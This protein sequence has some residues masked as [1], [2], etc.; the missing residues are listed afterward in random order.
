MHTFAK[1]TITQHI[2]AATFCTGLHAH[3]FQSMCVFVASGIQHAMRI[4]HI[5]ICGLP[6]STIFFHIFSQRNDFRKKKRSLS[7]K[8]VLI[9]PTT[10]AWNISHSKT[11]WGRCDKKSISLVW[12]KKVYR[13]CDQKMY[14]ALHVKY[15]LFLSDFNE[16]WNFSIDFRGMPKYQISWISVWWEPSCF[17]RT[18]M[19]KLIV[20]FCNFAEAPKRREL[21]RFQT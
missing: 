20:P 13:W 18:D 7:I 21:G 12:S 16:T 17:K 15:P 6:Q 19:T 10:F 1:P 4:R 5:V 9:F 11:K 3:R 2:F 14:I 8:C